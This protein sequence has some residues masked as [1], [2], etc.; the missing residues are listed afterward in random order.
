MK[1]LL[2][3]FYLCGAG[4]ADRRAGGGRL[5][6]TLNEIDSEKPPSGEQGRFF[7]MGGRFFFKWWLL[8]RFLAFTKNTY[9][10]K[11]TLVHCFATDTI[12]A[13]GGSYH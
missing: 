5:N 2:C 11:S 12:I 4:C 1:C 6:G 10:R 13:H 8:F 9:R 3:S 7:M